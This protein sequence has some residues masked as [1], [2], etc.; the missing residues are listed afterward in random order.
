MIN[1]P[2]TGIEGK[3][4]PATPRIGHGTPVIASGDNV[5]MTWFENAT[6]LDR[7]EVFSKQVMML[8]KHLAMLLI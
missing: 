1:D 4:A 2:I 8:A 3:V 7:P 5:Y 6:G